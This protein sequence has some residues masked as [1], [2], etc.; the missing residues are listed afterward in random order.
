V[1]ILAGI[2]STQSHESSTSTG[3]QQTRRIPPIAALAATECDAATIVIYQDDVGDIYLQGSLKNT[4][5]NGTASPYIPA[6]KIVPNSQEA[7]QNE[8]ELSVVCYGGSNSSSTTFLVSLDFLE[9]H[10][11]QTD[12]LKTIHVFYLTN[13]T[14][15]ASIWASTSQILYGNFPNSTPLRTQ[16]NREVIHLGWRTSISAVYVSGEVRLFFLWDSL[17]HAKLIEMWSMNTTYWVGPYSLN[18]TAYSEV[19]ALSAIVNSQAQTSVF[20]MDQDRQLARY[21]WGGDSSNPGSCFPHPYPYLLR[22]HLLSSKS[23]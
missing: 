9:L 23:R 18:A 22:K 15:N 20:F 19:S 1:G 17:P 10:G 8:T 13:V 14:F 7:Y 12:S 11:F 5:W 16:S 6:S 2:L 21:N 4:T 3:S